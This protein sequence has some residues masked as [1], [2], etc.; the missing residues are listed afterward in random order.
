MPKR[1]KKI[2][3]RNLEKIIF[4]S[5][6]DPSNNPKTY[7]IRIRENPA[8]LSKSR[9]VPERELRKVETTGKTRILRLKKCFFC[10]PKKYCAKFS[11]QTK[12]KKQYFLN[13]SVVFSNLFPFGEVHGVLVYN[14]KKHIVDPRSLNIKNWVDGIR[15]I[16]KIGKASKKKYVSMNINKGQKAGA[17]LEHF[18]SQFHCEDEPFSKTVLSMN[19]TKKL[20]KKSELWWKSWVMSMGEEGLVI[21][22][23]NASRTVMYGEWC[24]V[25]GKAEIVIMTMKNPSFLSMNNKEIGAVAK[26][27]DKGIKT[28]M[29]ISDQF[30]VVNMSASPDDD[31]CNQ[32]RIFSRS[33]F[34]D[35]A[36]SWEGYAEFMEETIPHINP[37]KLVEIAGKY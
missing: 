10:N 35:G 30:N 29:E 4:S 6:L 27:L 15:L 20:A 33:P 25:F 5:V 16:Q 8:F 31:F 7:E 22:F 19:L 36:K 14:Y 24:P 28:I 32:F 2:N 37:K 12:L 11:P 17:S 13:D 23:D 18:H 26:F 34:S 21:D 1:L 3:L 9:I